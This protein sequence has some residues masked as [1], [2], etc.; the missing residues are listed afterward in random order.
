[1][2]TNRPV[3]GGDTT[4]VVE[5]LS[6]RG[7]PVENLP[8]ELSYEGAEAVH[9]LTGAT[10]RVQA[11]WAAGAAGERKVRATVRRLPTTYLGVR[12][13]ASGSR[14][15]VAGRRTVREGTARVI[16]RARPQVTAIPAAQTRAAGRP[17]KV[18]L[19]T[20]GTGHATKALVRATLYG[21]FPSA[22]DSSC[23]GEKV[24]LSRR[25]MIVGDDRVRVRRISLRAGVYRWK[26]IRPD[27]AWNTARTTCTRP[28]RVVRR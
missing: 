19:T 25:A 18:W 14:V 1:M 9:A 11:A 3:V 27:D 7:R 26:V 17:F 2:T 10:G 24:A 21:P 23:A 4:V 8:V 6:A 22:A 16:V 13:P 20:S 12:V 5:V 28:L 15:A